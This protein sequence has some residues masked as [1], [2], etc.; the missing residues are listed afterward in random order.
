MSCTI[1]C[2][3]IPISSACSFIVICCSFIVDRSLSNISGE[4]PWLLSIFSLSLFLET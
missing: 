2:L 1:V 3:S 4:V